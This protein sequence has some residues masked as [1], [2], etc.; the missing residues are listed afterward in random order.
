M[1]AYSLTNTNQVLIK[2]VYRFKK[3]NSIGAAQLITTRQPRVLVVDDEPDAVKILSL[4][5]SVRGYQVV[6]ASD[7]VEAM[8]R[9]DESNVDLVLLDI[10]LPRLDGFQVCRQ[11]RRVSD[12]PIIMVSARGAAED[13]ATAL[14]IGA[15]DYLTKPFDIGD[16]MSKIRIALDQRPDDDP[17]DA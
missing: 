3:V 11:I 9:F 16:L 13:R 8:S 1:K 4:N 14:N 10:T 12:V 6:S 7:G 15:N 2:R 17:K 5:L